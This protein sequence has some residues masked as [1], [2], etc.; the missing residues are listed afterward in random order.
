MLYKHCHLSWSK[1]EWGYIAPMPGI[2]EEDITVI[3]ENTAFT[4]NT[5]IAASL[6]TAL[7]H[8]YTC[9]TAIHWHH[10]GGGRKFY[11][12]GQNFGTMPTLLKFKGSQRSCCNLE[13]KNSEKR[14]QRLI[15]E[16][17]LGRF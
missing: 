5:G 15:S 14:S 1:W 3:T 16:A 12:G 4:E 2:M 10:I 17:I 8:E 9:M 6:K 11:L 13:Q 7:L